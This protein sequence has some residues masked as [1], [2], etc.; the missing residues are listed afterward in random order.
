MPPRFIL[1]AVLLAA[2]AS[3][4]AEARYNKKKPK[5]IDTV[6]K[7][8]A[9]GIAAPDGSGPYYWTTVHV[10]DA[11]WFSDGMLKT[12][13]GKPDTSRKRLEGPG[14]TSFDAD[15][16]ER[17]YFD[18]GPNKW[19]RMELANPRLLLVKDAGVVTLVSLP[20][21]KQTPTPYA[22][23]ARYPVWGEFTNLVLIG[24]PGADGTVPAHFAGTDGSVG[25]AVPGSDLR[26]LVSDP[27]ANVR[28]C[29]ER[30]VS[31]AFPPETRKV[32]GWSEIQRRS[33]LP[34]GKTGAATLPADGSPADRCA[35]VMSHFFLAR[36]EQTGDWHVLRA[37][38]GTVVSTRGYATLAEAEAAAPAALARDTLVRFATIPLGDNA[39]LASA[40]QAQQRSDQAIVDAARREEEARKAAEAARLARERTE[41]E[42]RWAVARSRAKQYWDAGHY[43]MALQEAEAL[44]PEEYARFVLAWR[45]APLDTLRQAK[46]RLEDNR[47]SRV[48]NETA[49]AIDVR[50]NNIMWCQGHLKGPDGRLLSE[51]RSSRWASTAPYN[52]MMEMSQKYVA[53][54]R[55]YGM[56]SPGEI[57][58][59]DATLYEWVKIYEPDTAKR[60]SNRVINI[61]GDGRA[62]AE[63]QAAA[64]QNYERCVREARAR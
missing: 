8:E 61:P 57:L 3:Q 44:P 6:S 53:A 56:L 30:S 20:S 29:V 21:G 33:L 32:P 16:S 28:D 27:P 15:P 42:A 47:I 11:K 55:A 4:P 17:V 14:A 31:A 39:S 22:D 62:S 43:G 19:P 35:Q 2:I 59:F 50:Y 1:P 18:P 12:C 7:R 36:K 9:T 49:K 24:K 58:V 46:Q 41:A 10:C 63:Q 51:A 37:A 34:G 25:P 26:R 5:Q 45:D 54:S 60:T 40:V 64:Q 38:D 23:W 48:W 52:R 13:F